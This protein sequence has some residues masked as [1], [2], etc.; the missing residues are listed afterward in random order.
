MATISILANNLLIS[1]WMIP[2]LEAGTFSWKAGPDEVL[3]VE[4]K[5][6]ATKIRGIGVHIKTFTCSTQVY[7]NTAAK[8]KNSH[9]KLI[10]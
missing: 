5:I 10:L 4:K 2:P 8:P 3:T 9:A 7:G 6:P 1:D